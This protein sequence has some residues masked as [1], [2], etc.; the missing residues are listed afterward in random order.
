M[1][2][3]VTV[4]DRQQRIVLRRALSARKRFYK[5]ALGIS[6]RLHNEKA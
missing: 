4:S 5:E 3:S 6:I 2:V 1:S